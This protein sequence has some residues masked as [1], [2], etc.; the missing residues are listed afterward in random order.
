MSNN[1]YSVLE[2]VKQCSYPSHMIDFFVNIILEVVTNSPSAKVFKVFYKNENLTVLRYNVT[3]TFKDRSFDIPILIYLS[4]NMPYEA[5]EVYLERN[6]ETGVN[7]KNSDIDQKSNRIMTSG[8]L[9]W[10]S[11]MG[12]TNILL[13]VMASFNK[14]FPIYKIA[15]GQ[16]A[17][18]SQVGQGTIQQ[19][20]QN[21][22]NQNYSLYN[23]NSNLSNTNTYYSNQAQIQPQPQSS[24]FYNN[25]NN[26]N[27]NSNVIDHN[28]MTDKDIDSK[29]AYSAFT[30]NLVNQPPHKNT[31]YQSIYQ[32]NI[33]QMSAMNLN[34]PPQSS[35][36]LNNM[37]F[38]NNQ[39]ISGSGLNG[40]YYNQPYCNS[41]NNNLS[42]T[43]YVNQNQTMQNQYNPY[44]SN[45]NAPVPSSS[46]MYQITHID[47]RKSEDEMKRILIEEIKSSIENKIK[48]EI[49]RNKQTEEKLN[50][51][52]NEFNTQVD[53]HQKF[54]TK[55][56]DIVNGLKKLLDDIEKEVQNVQMYLAKMQDRVLD[57]TNFENYIQISDTALIN[58]VAVEA[59]VE[60]FLSVIKKAFEKNIL[61]FNETVRTIRTLTRET[62]KIKFYR[63]KLVSKI[64]QRKGK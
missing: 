43:Q 53:K 9:N 26:M 54:F 13:E 1:K 33:N 63:E 50:N 14:N 3:T 64:I 25:L 4:K 45:L 41:F 17:Q 11:R 34:K 10:N 20:M 42:N 52:R 62:L 36:V 49:K 32:S 56:E 23:N 24:N 8:L 51:Y 19:S 16:G 28:S 39:S 57:T 22:Q 37:Q 21:S 46:S 7:P 48:E 61:N 15:K 60:D 44:S 30:S 40:N 18:S 47:E 59:T 29:N 6:P 27:I 35:Q 38:Y 55:K 12:L 2:T 5:P 58:L 31:I